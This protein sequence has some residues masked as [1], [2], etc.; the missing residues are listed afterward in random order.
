M[1]RFVYLSLVCVLLVA[2]GCG[3]K[4]TEPAPAPPAKPTEPTPPT[5]AAKPT[6]PATTPATNPS[7]PKAVGA[8]VRGTV[9]HPGKS[10]Q[11]LSVGFVELGGNEPAGDSL[12]YAVPAADEVTQ[13]ESTAFPP[14]KAVVSFEKGKTTFEFSGLPAGPCFVFA[15]LD[16]GPAVWAKVEAKADAPV[17]QDLK[18]DEG[19]G[20]TVEVKT[21]ADFAGDVRLSPNEFIPADDANFAGGRIANQL[22]LGAKAKDG[23]AT[24]ADVPPGK[25]TLFVF[26]GAVVPR[27][28]VEVTAGKTVMVEL[29]AEKK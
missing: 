17:T 9:T 10:G 7:P 5:E 21:P 14:R 25:Y 28:T 24:V 19:K 2:I 1:S 22:E 12:A 27:G 13:V 26:P 6:T 15:R 23:K 18:L 3:P 11:K 20:G 8:T 4:P 16:G 29:M